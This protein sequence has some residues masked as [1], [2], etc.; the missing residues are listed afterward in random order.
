MTPRYGPSPKPDRTYTVRPGVY[1]ILIRDER[2]LLTFQNR[3]EREFQLPGGGIDPGEFTLHA[4]HREVREETGWHI[5][6]PRRLGAFR[7]FVWMPEYRI[8]A[9]KICHV[10]SARPVFEMGP[11]SEP[12]HRAVWLPLGSASRVL[13][14]EGDAAF[15]DR[16]SGARASCVGGDRSRRR[17]RAG[18]AARR[19]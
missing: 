15:L 10:Y 14:N 16:V 19:R 18:T 3:P 4:L 11:P 1:A 5:A 8:H 7:R 6:A 17:S 13:G 12:E 9:E 2:I